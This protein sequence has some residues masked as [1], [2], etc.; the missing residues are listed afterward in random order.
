MKQC[1]ICKRAA[2]VDRHH[3]H[4]RTYGGANSASNIAEL[5]KY[6]HDLVHRG[7]IVLEGRF[8][9]TA[10][11]EL[12]YHYEGEESITGCAPECYIVGT[13]TP[14]RKTNPVN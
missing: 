5:C 7:K 9:T 10:G 12:I 6:C 3:I 8:Q 2:Y 11:N 14:S 13:K 4:S 1:E